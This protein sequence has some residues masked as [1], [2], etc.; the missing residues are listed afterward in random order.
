MAVVPV[1]VALVAAVLFAWRRV[2]LL[3][4]LAAGVACGAVVGGAFWAGWRADAAAARSSRGPWLVSSSSD[5]TPGRYGETLTG[6]ITGVDRR[7]LRVE[8]RFGDGVRAPELRSVAAVSGTLRSVGRSDSDRRAHR[9]GVVARLS[10]TSVDG[11]GWPS[12]VGGLIGRVRLWAVRRLGQVPDEAGAL[13]S[14]VVLG[15]RRRLSGLAAEIDFRTTGLSHLVAVSGSHLVVVGVLVAWVLDGLRFRRW[16]SSAAVIVVMAAYVVATG[17]QASAIRALAMASIAALIGMSP[18]R[19][20]RAG[21]LVF[22]AIVALVAW[23]PVA[24]DLG[25]QLSV[26]AVAGLIVFGR[27]MTSWFRAG[28]PRWAAW[29]AEPLSLTVV[30]QISTLPVAAP[31]FGTVSVIAPLA[32]LLAGPL[33]AFAL[34]CGL[35]G[36]VVSVLAEP[37]GRA[38]IAISAAA[39]GATV[40]VASWL[41]RVPGAAVTVPWSGAVASVCVLILGFTTWVVWPKPRR[42]TGLVGAAALSLAVAMLVVGPPAHHGAEVVVL[43]VGQGDAVLVRDGPHAALIDTGPSPAALSS[44]LRR[45]GV[46]RLDFLALTHAHD[47][48]SGGIAAATVARSPKALL[49]SKGAE[50]SF[51]TVGRVLHRDASGLVAGQRVVMGTTS[52]RVLWPI[53]PVHDAADNASSLVLLVEHDDAKVLL[54]GDAESDVLDRLARAGALPDVD[55]LKVGHHGSADAVS[56]VSLQALRP[57]V[58]VI[59]VGAD[60]RFGHPHEETLRRLAECGAAVRRTDRDGDVRIPLDGKGGCAKLTRF[61]FTNE[62]DADGRPSR[63]AE[64]R[65]PHHQRAEAARRPGPLAPEEARGRDRGP[66]LQHE[67]LRRGERRRRRGHRGQQ[68]VAVRKRA[69]PR[70]GTQH[71]EDAEVRS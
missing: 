11:L 25:F 20:D 41:A 19:V 71:R 69:P 49:V 57:E 6:A 37:V 1:A 51:E 7:R 36:L 70:G 53:T 65:V 55:V 27:L 48:H 22:A 38:L 8:A 2:T 35:S 68:H 46:G 32:N 64:A 63:R 29:L 62:A 42:E 50:K 66:R 34:V 52:L 45:Q 43:D 39:A 26:A 18:R 33:V 5:A 17:C 13:L 21:T 58:A 56:E 60:N 24:F 44:A 12:G 54:T 28:L 40:A 61:P 10:V 3:T 16:V 59:S 67:R 4:L 9:S 31:A 30:A 23:P 14:G 47:D 15:D